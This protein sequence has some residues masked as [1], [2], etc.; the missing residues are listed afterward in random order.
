MGRLLVLEGLDGSGK[1]TQTERLKQA[2]LETGETV[3][4]IKLP[5]YDAPSSTGRRTTTPGPS[6]SRTGTRRPTPSTR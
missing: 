6:S 3:R 2:L 5:D 1:S 4:Q